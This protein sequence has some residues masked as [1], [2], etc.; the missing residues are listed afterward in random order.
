MER[1]ATKS[2]AIL[3]SI[4]I[5]VLSSLAASLILGAWAGLPDW[6][7]WTVSAGIG[8]FVLAI[9]ATIFCRRR[10]ERESLA[11]TRVASDI[12]AKNDVEAGNITV[13]DEAAKKS[14]KVASDI[15]SKKGGV[16]IEGVRVGG[17]ERKKDID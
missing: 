3:V 7:R 13:E 15:V 12:Q 10:P 6:G 14:V 11:E 9:L 16:V 2:K 17:D 4:V 1:N 5:G 8:V